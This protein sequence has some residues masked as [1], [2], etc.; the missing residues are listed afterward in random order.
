MQMRQATV[1]FIV[2]YLVAPWVW[3]FLAYQ[4]SGAHATISTV[5][6]DNCIERPILIY[7]AGLYA[8]GTILGLG[9]HWFGERLRL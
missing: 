7:L 9:W 1:C 5:I 3:S 4:L 6:R 8:G 2:I